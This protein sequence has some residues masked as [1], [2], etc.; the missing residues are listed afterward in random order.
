MKKALFFALLLSLI[1]FLQIRKWVVESGPLSDSVTVIV[2]KG[3]TSGTV[4]R[5]LAQA[6]VIDKPWLF[7]VVGRLNGLD[8]RIR[9][10]EYEFM[11]RMSLSE[12]LQKVTSG[13]VYYRKITF[14]EGMTVA[15]F[16]ALL[17]ENPVLSGVINEPAKEGE[18]LPE[19]YS[20]TYGDSRDSII[21]RAKREMVK[22]LTEEWEKRAAGLPLKSPQE[23]L[24]LASVVEKETGVEAERPQV[25]SVFVNRL[26]KGMKLQTD[27]TVIYAL[28]KGE[29]ELGR[30]LL[31]KD[32]GTDS[33]YNTYKYYGLPPAPICN[34]GTEAIRAAAH[35]ADTDYLYFVASGDG[36]HNFAK[37]LSDHN[38]NVK[39]WRQK[40]K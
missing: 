23:L 2:P 34:P 25:A 32:L 26:R 37:S 28:T 24:I 35:P 12:T 22:V 31:K 11:P 30:P 4:A 5:L 15:Q 20:F 13:E 17:E 1:A 18:L 19:T 14:A 3:A 33:P 39:V 7:R 21:V 16:V 27:P 6:G 8:K 10:G 36:G 9:A 29:R 38:R 40:N